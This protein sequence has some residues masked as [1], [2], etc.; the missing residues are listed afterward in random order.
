MGDIALIWTGNNVGD[1][2]TTDFDLVTDT[3]L[4]TAVIVSLFS[5]R[6]APADVEL[7][8]GEASRRGWWGDVSPPAPGD[9][10]GSHLWLLFREKQLPQVL[11]RAEEYARAALQW[12]IDDK[13]ARRIDV[14]AENT[15]FQ[16]IDL[17]ITIYRP[18]GEEAKFRYTYAWQSQAAKIV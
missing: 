11:A 1:I 15:R 17:Q 7:P 12:M 4:E 3:G 2:A 6:R 8:P 9:E 14:A 13:I 16:Q 5:D 18:T 10:I